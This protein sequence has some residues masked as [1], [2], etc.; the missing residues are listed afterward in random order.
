MANL[1]NKTE[2]ARVTHPPQFPPAAAGRMAASLL[3]RHS[4]HEIAEA[5]TVLIDVLDLIGGDVDLED[6]GDDELTGDEH[7]T[8]W[9]EWQSRGRFKAAPHEMKSTD[10]VHEDD[11]DDDPDCAQDEGEPN[12]AQVSGDDGSAGCSIADPG[13]CEH[14][15][16]EPD[17]DDEIQPMQDDVPM[18]P[19]VSAEHNVFNDQRVSL[20]LSN[21][22]TSFRTN[23][24]KVLS[25]DSGEILVTRGFE[26]KPGV[27]V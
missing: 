24:G 14:D 3:N 23:G 10:G 8:G 1:T 19:V 21:L 26:R 27:P 13:G 20:G 25:A 5:V 6:G 9:P 22:Q 17:S 11:E 2:S 7:D 12:F 4:A 16:R 18:L 15:G